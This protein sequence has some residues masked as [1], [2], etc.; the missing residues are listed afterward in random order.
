MVGLRGYKLTSALVA[1][2]A[3][4]KP[5]PRRPRNAAFVQSH[6]IRYRLDSA[7]IEELLAEYGR[8]ATAAEL[9]RR[10]GVAKSSVL[11][12]LHGSPVPVRYRRFSEADITQVV[13]L[14]RQGV[15]QAEIAKQVGRGAGAVW[16]ILERAGL[17]GR[18]SV[19]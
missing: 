9:G 8:G 11:R 6:R 1:F 4:P 13:T 18:H 2:L 7:A 5:R 17:V 3:T 19:L 10:Y 15:P 14:Y 12:I 16:H